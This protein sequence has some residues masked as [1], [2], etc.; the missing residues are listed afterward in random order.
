MK[1][2][3]GLL[4]MGALFCLPACGAASE[5]NGG[6]GDDGWGTAGEGGDGDGDGWGDGDGDGD[7]DSGGDGDGEGGDDGAGEGGDGDGDGDIEPGQLTAGEYRDLDHWDFWRGLFEGDGEETG[8]WASMESKWGY[9][10]EN[11]FA[12]VVGSGD[13]LVG[14]AEVTLVDAEQNI[15]WAARTDNLGRAE[16]Y[17]GLF[18]EETTG[19]YTITVDAAAQSAQVE[20][21]GPTKLGDPIFIPLDEAPP[22][23]AALDLMFVIDTT[24][25]M[26]DELS[27]LQ[28]ELADVIQRV[29]NDAAEQLDIRLSVNFYRDVGDDYTVRPFPFTSDI[30]TAVSQLTAQSSGGGGDYPEAVEKGL[31]S[32]VYDHE[33][34]TAARARL[35]FLVLDAPPHE[36][37]QVITEL[38]EITQEA[39]DQGIRIIPLAASG[40]NKDTEFLMRFMDVS[41]G[42]TYTF[43]TDHSGIGGDHIEPTIGDYEVELLN[44]L[45]VRLISESVG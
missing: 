3:L 26:G 6:G 39:A 5:D 19:P 21:E 29:E 12:V 20:A 16:L 37:P 40:T 10:T 24:G 30:G 14:D 31:A 27:Y 41:T 34:S 15:V 9:F 7:G 36:Q 33:W 42:G 22:T 1:N 11:R 8:A 2:L 18:G 25:S 23:P 28:A 17:A 35:L 13:D 43:L 45:L 32:G 38:H 4:T 44:D